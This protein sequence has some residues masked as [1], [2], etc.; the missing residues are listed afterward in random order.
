MVRRDRD[1]TAIRAALDCQAEVCGVLLLGEPGVGKTTLARS[2]TQSL[3]VPAHWVAGTESA[4]TVPLGIFAHLL[5]SPTSGDPIA[6]LAEAFETVRRER[7]SVIGVDDVHLVD[8]LSATLLHQLAVE[9]SVRIVAT[10]RT[11]EPI[12]ETITALWKD[13]YL[14]RMDVTAF[15]KAESVELIESA[16]AGRLE[17][18]SAD[19][20]WEASGGNALFMRHLVDGALETGALRRVNGVWQLR[21]QATVTSQL[22]DLLSGRVDRLP[23]DE[24][25]ALRFLAVAEPLP[26]AIL[27]ELVTS[28]TLERAERRG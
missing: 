5:D 3:R 23:D 9:G 6:M 15:S 4:R 20:V 16:L 18:L 17:Q 8:H 13:G 24:K 21:G 12:P 11:G 7:F 28:D 2:V 1:V 27:G 10:A 19:L 14:T 26:L 22:A 25:R